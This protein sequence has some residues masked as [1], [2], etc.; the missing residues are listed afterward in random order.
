M[1]IRNGRPRGTALA[2]GPEPEILTQPPFFWAL[3]LDHALK[4]VEFLRSSLDNSERQLAQARDAYR[5]T[6]DEVEGLR[7]QFHV[8]AL[9]SAQAPDLSLVSEGN[10]EAERLEAE[11]ATARSRILELQ[12]E[13]DAREAMQSAPAAVAEPMAEQTS[14]RLA[15]AETQTE[16][17]RQ[18][19]Q[20][21]QQEAAQLH[22]QLQL[23]QQELTSIRPE[24][25][26]AQQAQHDLAASKSA[27]E[28]EVSDLR[29]R[30]SDLVRDMDS[31]RQQLADQAALQ[32]ELARARGD[33]A[34]RDASLAEL[35]QRLFQQESESDAE[36][37]KLQ[38]D[39]AQLTALAS[40]WEPSLLSSSPGR[41]EFKW[42]LCPP[43]TTM[44][45]L[46]QVQ[47]LEEELESV[48]GDTR[49]L[50]DRLEVRH[51]G[52]G[53]GAR[54]LR[55]TLS[56]PATGRRRRWLGSWLRRRRP[57]ASGSCSRPRPARRRRTAGSWSSTA[58][59]PSWAT[60]RRPRRLEG[61]RRRNLPVTSLGVVSDPFL[62][63]LSHGPPTGC[64]G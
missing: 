49:A 21:A 55:V 11:L 12:A 18:Q 36:V 45:L 22:G 54:L 8:S 24:L 30:L 52:G 14:A 2:P 9:A 37:L 62:A 50:S 44:R 33:V 40:P 19:L 5:T 23:A 6:K 7:V 34:A 56:C 25:H 35:Q 42:L 47:K 60:P 1:P 64:P 20:L 3:Q 28:A 29:A 41:W 17:L 63:C 48:R 43:T 32:A 16:S 13:L 46:C 58:G 26:R 31:A 39:S 57:R 59:L 38:R 15:A 61:R 53:G 4:E 51:L 10:P 27:L